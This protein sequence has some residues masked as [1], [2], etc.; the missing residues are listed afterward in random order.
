[1]LIRELFINEK[2]RYNSIVKH[3]V[4]SWEWGDAKE[5]TGKKVF[6]Y[7]FFDNTNMT[8]G[9]Q[10]SLHP[11]P[12]PLSMWNIGY[13]PKCTLPTLEMLH[14][15]QAFGQKNNCVYIK[16]EPNVFGPTKDPNVQSY[17]KSTR[18]QL[19]ATKDLNIIQG[20]ELFTKYNFLLDI[21]KSDEELLA[22]M[23]EK[24]R[25]NIGLAQRKGVQIQE[26]TDEEGFKIFLKL[27]F[28]T[29]K[30]Q[31]YY[32]HDESYHRHIWETLRANDMARLLIAYY[33]NVPT[34]IWLVTN[35]HNTMYYQYGGSTTKFRNVMSSNLVAWSAIQLGKRMG[36]TTL[37][38]W[39]A[40]SLNPDPTD[41]WYGFH[42][43]K[44]GYGP[45]HIEYLGS[46]DLITN[47]PMYQIY[48]KLDKYRSQWLRFKTK[49][50]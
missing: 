27:Y 38:L 44:E 18:E 3:I 11:L 31:G 4:Q 14:S 39:G 25:Y 10:L 43:F 9:F 47:P 48:N 45:T 40:M 42:R 30:R 32:G 8:D 20:K 1:M 21:T 7:G 23:H 35:F 49:F 2:E 15:L 24:T 22:N 12:A 46:Y 13:L 17:L 36:L 29:T 50:R 6:K 28:E 19:L 34:S 16:L 5:A 37:D 26:R 41:P 33:D